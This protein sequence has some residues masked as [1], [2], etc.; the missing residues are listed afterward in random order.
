MSGAQGVTPEIESEGARDPRSE[1][2]PDRGSPRAQRLGLTVGPL[3]FVAI[4]AIPGLPL[5]SAQRSVAA[6]TGLVASLW[7][8]VAIPV[9]AAALIPAA[10]FP[11]LGVMTARQ[12]APL[13]LQ[14]LVI[15]FIGAFIVALGLE[16]FG[17]HRRIALS[18]L[19]RVGARPRSL[20][21][22]FM[23]ASA[24]LSMWINNTATT[25]MMLP[26]GLAVVQATRTEAASSEDP[27]AGTLD[28][29]AVCLLLGMAYSASVGG[30]GTPVGTAPNQEFLGQLAT[31]FEAAPIPSFG[32]WFVAWLPLVVAF[33][34]SAWWV[35]TRWLFRIDDTPRGG[36]EVI[37]SA[38][39]E[40][41]TMD[42]GERR[43]AAVFVCTALLWVTRADLEIGRISI[44][45]W[46]RIL[47]AL[48]PGEQ[49]ANQVSASTVAL[50]M[51]VL[52]FVI[53]S[54]R[55]PGD[56]LMDW[57]TAKRL[58]W[59]V[60]LLLGGGICIAR[61]FKESGLDQVLGQ[62]LAPWFEGRSD[63]VVVGMVVL[64]LSSLTEITSNTAT[65]AV[66][67]PVIAQAAIQAGLNPLLL[68]VPAT[69]AASSAF[70]M[71]VAT[72]PNAVVFT[73]RLIPMGTMARVGIWLNLLMVVLITLVFEF[74][75][76]RIWGIESGLPDWASLPIEG[77]E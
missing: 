28:P 32:A 70:A 6:V 14:D 5:D 60:L 8:T 48:V 65:T 22:G 57:S 42:S 10:L 15:L 20:V 52:C 18:I 26:I 40:L 7:I 54:G 62:G 56:R 23:G 11:L 38:R 61:G 43:M 34:L 31:N 25:L 76:R 64:F 73:S 74:W 41:G 9:G 21:L 24:F 71:P 27:A 69:I 3:L 39:E 33:V 44:P 30:M 45:G 17:V 29:F 16:R 59:D 47:Y 12:V 51:A 53:P 13:Y 67:L 55:A 37:A 72:P 49:G 66:L 2:D 46:T 77:G 63:I 75:V 35:M 68:M 1:R 50:L 36:A 4:L 58:P 19:A